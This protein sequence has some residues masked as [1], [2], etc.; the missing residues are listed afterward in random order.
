MA[1]K[2]RSVPT[3]TLAQ[4]LSSSGTTLYISD[5]LDWD[6]VQLSSADFGS[7]AF[8]VLRNAA[9]TQI[10]F[11]EIDETTITSSNAI[12]ILK[13]GL[14]YDGTQVADTETKYN[15]N[16]FDTYVELGADTPQLL[17]QLVEE[18]GD[19]TIAGVKTFSSSPIVPTPTT[20]TQAA[21]KSYAD[22]L[23]IAG[24][25]DSDDT[26]KGIL[27]RATMAEI[28][29]GTAAGSTTAPLA[30][31]S[32]RL[33]ARLYTAYA[34]DAGSN[35]TYVITCAPVPTAYTAGMV[36]TFKANTINTGACTVNVNSLGAKDIQKRVAG[37]LVALDDGDIAAGAIITC[38]YNGTQFELQSRISKQQV[39]QSG[40][41]I[42]AASSGGTDTYA[43]TLSP[44]PSAYVTGQV[45]RF[46]ADVANTGTASLNVNSLGALTLKKHTPIG[47]AALDTGDILA[48]QFVEVIH[49]GTD[50]TIIS[51]LSNPQPGLV[52]STQNTTLTANTSE[53]TVVTYTI[54]AGQ[55]STKHGVRIKC[56]LQHLAH[57]NGDDVTIKFKFGATTFHTATL[58]GAGVDTTTDIGVYEV[59]VL[60]N[61][62]SAQKY[63]VESMEM[64]GLTTFEVFAIDSGTIAESTTGTVAVAVTSQTAADGT[65]AV[66][67]K[68]ATIEYVYAV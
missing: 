16:A 18:A 65:N 60:N 24:A 12:T 14:G 68:E 56:K 9:N 66:E 41:E 6:G 67:V 64:S 63:S 42:Y 57:A 28:E 21:N 29:A 5:T 19:E 54:P 22:G 39:S 40:A 13:R 38:I 31:V 50:L 48:N 61:T 2:P 43:I 30:V 15:W 20:A 49:N 52:A 35:D 27:E 10:E 11:I 53:Q 51:P 47:L 4:N 46:K 23:A 8:A 45:F 26:T 7:Q 1:I 17:A 58:A 44:A 36:I 37:G 59:L 3:K 32:G 34:A 25:P 55:L 33:G 62:T